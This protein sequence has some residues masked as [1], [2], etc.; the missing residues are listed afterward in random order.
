MIAPL[1]LAASDG[2]G[3]DCGV[4]FK[5]GPRTTFVS[6]DVT[7]AECRRNMA[8]R[9]AHLLAASGGGAASPPSRLAAQAPEARGEG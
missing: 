7:C 3:S 6:S 5:R 2:R 1:H 4:S 8:L 9:R